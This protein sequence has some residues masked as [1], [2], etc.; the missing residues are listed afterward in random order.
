M[1]ATKSNN[2]VT[3][4][5][6]PVSPNMQAL[7]AFRDISYSLGSMIES[8]EK[9]GCTVMWSFSLNEGS[10]PSALHI[11]FSGGTYK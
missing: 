4:V 8:L 2:K 9:N 1:D 10:E 6:K 11:E 7:R 3:E 5:E